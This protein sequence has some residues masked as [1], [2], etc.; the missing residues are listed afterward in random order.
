MSRLV[1]T[2]A[3][4]FRLQIR[5][6]FYYAVVLILA[7]F[8]LL[9]SLAPDVDWSW[10]LAPMILGNLT[11]ATF[12]FVGGL[13][14]LEKSEGTLEAQI[15]SPLRTHEYIGSKVLTLTILSLIENL[16]IVAIL[17]GFEHRMGLLAI[18]VTAASVIYILL[19]FMVVARF[20][21]INE[22]LIP[23]A[24]V[25]TLLSVPLLDYFEVW[26]TPL[27]TLH[28]LQGALT[29]IRA[30]F[31]EVSVTEYV[32][33]MLSSCAWIGLYFRLSQRTYRRFVVRKEGD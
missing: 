30:A 1:A 5:G 23:S 4:D 16:A 33:G 21:S 27:M 2:L 3:T 24:L 7:A 18:G 11:T 10:W 14:L 31:L 6:G 13:V 20:D 8:A 19:G 29:L 17:D 15:V 32:L 25:V 9:A 26:R 22:Y 12:Y 28:P